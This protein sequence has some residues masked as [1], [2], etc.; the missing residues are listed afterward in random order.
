MQA[1]RVSRNFGAFVSTSIVFTKSA[2]L[3]ILA[4]GRCL[5]TP[6]KCSR[7]RIATSFT[8]WDLGLTDF[9][10]SVIRIISLI[11]LSTSIDKRVSTCSAASRFIWRGCTYGVVSPRGRIFE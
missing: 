2:I 11:C 7:I 8:V 5:R 9:I 1:L 6:A 4:R 3:T 10:A